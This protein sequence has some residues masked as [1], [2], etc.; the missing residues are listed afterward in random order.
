METKLE[1][2][3]PEQ[4]MFNLSFMFMKNNPEMTLAQACEF[5]TKC[6]HVIIE[7]FQRQGLEPPKEYVEATSLLYTRLVEQTIIE[8]ER[9]G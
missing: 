9:N 6:G 3:N 2:L 4:I 7:A 8:N 1:R 5:G